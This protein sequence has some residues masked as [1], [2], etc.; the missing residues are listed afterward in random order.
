[1]FSKTTLPKFSV[2][3]PIYALENVINPDNLLY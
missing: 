1:M 3:T 2:K